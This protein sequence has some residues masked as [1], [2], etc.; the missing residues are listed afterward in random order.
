MND[1]VC[2]TM[3]HVLLTDLAKQLNW[4]GKGTKTAFSGAKIHLLIAS[5]KHFCCS[6]FEKIYYV[7]FN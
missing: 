6:V 1:T 2:R 5:K 4:M 7:I 3:R